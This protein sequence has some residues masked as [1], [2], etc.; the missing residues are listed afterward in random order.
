MSTHGPTGDGPDDPFPDRPSHD[1]D[2]EDDSPHDPFSPSGFDDEFVR[3]ASFSEPS[4][5]ERLA[6]VHRI[7]EERRRLAAVRRED[8]RLESGDGRRRVVGGVFRSVVAVVALVAV[9]AVATRSNFL[10]RRRVPLSSNPDIHADIS[11]SRFELTGGMPPPSTE[12]RPTPLGA[13]T[14]VIEGSGP[15]AFMQTQGE[16][17]DQKP[18]SGQSSEASTAPPQPG[19]R[20]EPVTYDPCRPVHVVMNGRSAPENGERL[21]REGLADL[22]EAT[23]LVFVFDG[24]TDESPAEKRVPYQPERYPGRWAPVLLAWSDPAESPFLAGEAAGSGGSLALSLPG[25]GSVYVTGQVVLDGPQLAKA[26][27]GP[28]GARATG[29]VIRHELGHLVGLN[30]V[31]DRTQIMYPSTQARFSDY[32]AGDL[33]GLARLG[34]GACFPD[35]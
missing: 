8:E 31:D 7:S 28:R 29:A 16:G 11:S 19:P 17:P 9:A 4:A 6:R 20:S 23:G 5:Q 22:A 3:G 13:P 25:R 2:F 24:L 35:I 34:R 1:D 27:D 15:F 32:A 10:D 26:L 18:P 33:L 12:S 21:M 14:A 30:H